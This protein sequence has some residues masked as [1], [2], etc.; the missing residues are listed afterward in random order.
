MR[1]NPLLSRYG[2]VTSNISE[3]VNNMFAQAQNVWW[4]E[5]VESIVDV[6]STRISTCRAKHIDREP[7][8]VV[9]RVAQILKRRWDAA[10][11]I[12]LVELVRGWGD[13]KVVEPSTVQESD[14]NSHLPNM[15]FNAGQPNTIYIV[16]PELQWWTCGIW[17]DVLY[18]C[19]HGCAVFRKRKEKDFSYVL[20]N[21]VHPYDKFECV[22]QMYTNNILP[23]CIDNVKYHDTTRPPVVKKPQRGGGKKQTP[24]CW[25]SEF[26]DP[27]ESPI[28]CS[29]C[30]QRGHNKRT[31]KNQV[32]T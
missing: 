25:R 2:F 6:M 15:P 20:Q 29:D 3:C 11:S 27:D 16:K 12:T 21:L 14:N 7:G 4:L 5:A 32:R 24:Y 1:K 28:T 23:A 22:K 31:C 13:F 19:W 18:P 9:P 8:E 30:G 17:Q 26:L 10:A